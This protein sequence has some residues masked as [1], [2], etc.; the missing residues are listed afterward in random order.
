MPSSELSKICF[1]EAEAKNASDAAALLV[2]AAP[3]PPVFVWKDSASSIQTYSLSNS[4]HQNESAPV[5]VV[6]NDAA[7]S[8]APVGIPLE[9]T[10]SATSTAVP[11]PSQSSKFAINA[12]VIQRTTSRQGREKQRWEAIPKRGQL[13][14]LT[15]GA[16]PIMKDGRILLCSSSRKEEWILP[17]GGWDNDESLEESAIREV[18]EEGGVIGSLGPRL[19]EVVYETKKAKKRRLEREERLQNWSK[20]NEKVLPRSHDSVQSENDLSM[21]GPITVDDT[22]ATPQAQKVIVSTTN[23]AKLVV[24]DADSTVA[25]AASRLRVSLEA[26]GSIGTAE[27]V[28]STVATGGFDDTGSVASAASSDGTTHNTHVKLSLFVLYVSECLSEWPE[29]GRGRKVVSIDEAISIMT[30]QNRPEFCA[31]LIEVKKKG[32]HAVS[33]AKR[34]I[35]GS[36]VKVNTENTGSTNTTTPSGNESISADVHR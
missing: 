16:V 11:P 27:S 15:T 25:G 26:E 22:T 2:P 36:T 30:V 23:N 8:A 14:R 4:S 29:S 34:E 33:T 5:P 1:T 31:G 12:K 6:V 19:T 10:P 3:L 13:Y 28:A 9:T 35:Q 32:L 21:N 17:K 7:A 18:Y 20:N 24:S